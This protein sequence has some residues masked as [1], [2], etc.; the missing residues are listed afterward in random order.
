MLTVACVLKSGVWKPSK[1]D[2]GYSFSHVE[3]LHRKV[4]E[5]LTL[6]HRFVCL[7]DVPG[8]FTV[9]LLHDWPGWWSKM[10]LFRPGLFEGPVLY[11]DLDTDIVGNIDHMVQ[12]KGFTAL[13]NLSSKKK[14]R[15]GSGVMFWDKTPNY[16]YASFVQ[17][18]EFFMN[19]YCHT[20]DRWG[21]QGFLQE[22]LGGGFLEWQTLFPNQIRSFKLDP[23][24][25]EDRIICYHGKGKSEAFIV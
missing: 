9:P 1:L 7:S 19:D 2:G 25:P 22:H 10:E 11:I 6:P 16:L 21:D 20:S 15:M 3:R 14:G 4:Q 13:R 17:R 12:H 18:P 8:A 23:P 5:H 24:H